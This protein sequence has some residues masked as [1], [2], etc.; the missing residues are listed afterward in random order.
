MKL[1]AKAMIKIAIINHSFQK[2]FYRNRWEQFANQYPDCELFL[3][4]PK[5]YKW[6]DSKALTFGIEEI[7]KTSNFV[8]KTTRFSHC[9]RQICLFLSLFV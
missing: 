8:I 4:T 6:G 5:E 1:R 7:I 3:I 9:S 2:P